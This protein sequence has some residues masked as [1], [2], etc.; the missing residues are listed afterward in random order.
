[1]ALKRIY[2][3][4]LAVLLIATVTTECQGQYTTDWIANTFGTNAARVGN[5]ARSM[6][7]APEG[8]IYTASMW[9]ENEGGI[10]IYQNGQSIGS[11]GAHGEM[12]GGAITGNASDVFAALQFNTAYGSGCVGRYD[13]TSHNRD[14]LIHVS[15]TTTERHADVITGLAISGSLLYASD[16][17]GNRVRVYTS[18]G[19]WQQDINVSGPGSLAIDGTGNIWVAQKSAGTV[20]EFNS[21]GTPLNT[22]QISASARPSAL[23]FDAS[24]GQLM[25]GDEGPDMNI[26]IYNISSTPFLASTFGIQGGYLDTT[27]GIK[28]RVGDKRFTRVAGIGKD[29]AGN[30]YVLNNPW[31]GTWDLGRDGGTDIHSYDSSGN[32]Q[33]KLQSLNFEG[34]AAPDSGTDGAYF[35]GGTNIYT[36]S[37]GGIFV[38]NTVDPID[39][40]SDPRINLNDQG[41]GE[42]FG[43][44]ATV[45]A[46]RILVA[47]GQNP[48]IFYFFHFNTANGYIAIPDGSIPGT[49]FN[50]TARI[51]DGF[52]LDSHGDVWAGL[53]KTNAIWHYPLLGF[54]SNGKPMWG[55]GI[56][57]SIPGTI[58]PLTRIIYLPE[59]DTMILAQGIVGS[60]DWTSIGTRVEVYHGWQAGNT[61]TPNPVINITS[62]NP[63]SIT[64]SGNYLFVGY[65]HTVPNID[66]FNLTTG[67]VDTTLINSNPDTVYVGNDVD[68]MYG[69][70][71]YLRS[72]GE[73]MVTKDNYNG[74]S[75]VVYRWTPGSTVPAAPT[76]LTAAGGNGQVSLAWTVSSGATSY[77][78]K[79]AAVS[80]G[81]Y[82]TIATGITST[83]YTDTGL[84][85]GTSYYYVVSAVNISGESLNS[86]EAGATTVPAAPT[87]LS[88]T[89]GNAQVSLSWT[90]SFGATSYKIR[91][92]TVSGGSY[93]TIA[94]GLTA[95]SY[96]DTGL[97][98]G[99]TYYYVVSAVDTGGEGANSMEV[100]AT[101]T[102]LLDLDIGNVGVAGS[103]AYSS[104]TYTINGSG[105]DVWDANDSFNYDYKPLTGDATVTARV[106]SQQDTAA[107]AKAGV[108]IRET[109]AANS[110][111]VFMFVTP[112]Q[113]VSLQYRAS[114]GGSAAQQAEVFG[115]TAPYWVRLVRAGNT[116]T[117][118]VSADG[119]SWTQVGS[120]SVT[121]PSS[122]ME[123]LAV[124]SHNNSQLNTSTFDNVTAP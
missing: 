66:A 59:S 90:G 60:T 107:W 35:Y 93:A 12:Q 2:T 27:A 87:G 103:A 122:V 38:A 49:L 20:L 24:T 23:Y 96:T 89:A 83:G 74:S 22:I 117:G 1:M 53:D 85:N 121:M 30:L 75:I 124:T 65:V 79:H 94:S 115:L 109:T 57:T 111:F 82:T 81:P 32:L 91:R 44:L 80:G 17:P 33:W 67:A 71:S 97:A 55:A 95:T 69:L 102:D 119:V 16:L 72:T 28:G 31:G 7:V 10:A 104:G 114:T 88:T 112:S 19:V 43:Q 61:T 50:T 123:G 56:S 64:A 8:V 40:P 51:R 106:A 73:Y 4:F 100:S 63:K 45:G 21:A 62:T 105:A 11:I 15:A 77:N 13:R 52:C 113:G 18:A 116:F 36:G 54:D 47:A 41:R 58:T 46:N 70:R 14:V 108:M 84:A 68:S 5:V 92:A 29:S 76:G 39:Y 86:A 3:T 9:D 118:Y 110:T 37:S 26:K 99:T 48:D 120:V 101:P 25:V 78:V 42:H 98:N 6:W 34:I